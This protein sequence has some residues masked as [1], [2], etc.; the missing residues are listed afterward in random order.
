MT[1]FL[2]LLMLLASEAHAAGWTCTAI[3]YEP[4][5]GGGPG[6]RRDVYGPEMP[7]QASAQTRAV[8]L[9]MSSGLMMCGVGSC[10]QLPFAAVTE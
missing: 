2:S 5:Y 7:T 9:C 1:I 6:R 3:G 10:S 4:S 8:Q